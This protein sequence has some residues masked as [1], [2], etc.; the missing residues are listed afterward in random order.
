MVQWRVII[1]LGGRCKHRTKYN[2]E[3]FDWKLC[4]F[5]RSVRT[6]R[7]T[8]D[9]LGPMPLLICQK[10]RRQKLLLF[11][12]RLDFLHLSSSPW[13]LSLE[14]T[15]DDTLL[16]YAFSCTE[17]FVAGAAL[18]GEKRNLLRQSLCGVVNKSSSLLIFFIFLV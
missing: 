16:F 8:G 10:R 11:L 7:P 3:T 14:K 2:A 12:E 15:D 6:G 9:T 5:G 13:F 4:C 1:L 17:P 18:R